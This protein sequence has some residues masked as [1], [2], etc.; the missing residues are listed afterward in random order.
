MGRG[1]TA[2]A[3]PAEEETGDTDVCGKLKP[4]TEDAFTCI[5]FQKSLIAMFFNDR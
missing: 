4:L 5:S 1:K 2:A 3:Q